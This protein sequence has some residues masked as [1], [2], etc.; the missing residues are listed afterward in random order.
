MAPVIP[1]MLD[2]ELV[3]RGLMVSGK[4]S[5]GVGVALLGAQRHVA[6]GHVIEHALS[7]RRNLLGH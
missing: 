3:R 1:D 4:A 2:A 5:D 7:E 6:E